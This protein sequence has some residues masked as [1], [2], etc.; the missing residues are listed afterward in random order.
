MTWRAFIVG[1]LL[2]ASIAV[3]DPYTSFNQNYGWNTQSHLPPGA[4]LALV[5]A[6]LALNGVLRLISRKASLK[7]AELMLIW[8]MLIV[9]CAVPSN[10]MRFWPPLMA[11]PAYIAQRPD[12]QWRDTALE[13]APEE[14]LLTKDPHSTAAERF[15]EGWPH[16]EGRVPWSMWLAPMSRWAVL[17]AFFYVATFCMCA[18]MRRQW[19]DRERLQFPLAR[20]PLDFTEGAGKD[21]FLPELFG[22]K[23]FLLGL[24][25]AAGFRALR[26]LPVLFGAEQVWNIS[27]PL[28]DVF[29]GTPL[30]G[31]QL[32]NF[33]LNWIAIGL[34]YLV[35]ADVSLSVWLF[36]LLGRV[37][38]QTSAWLGSTLHHGGTGSQLVRWQR[39]GA[40]ATF[41]VGALYMARRHLRDVI[42]K[43]FGRGENVDD[44]A[45]PIS[46]RVAFWGVVLCSL[47]ALWWF[48]H[49][50]MGLPAALSFF[51][52]LMLTQFAHARIVAQSGLYRTSPLAN[53]PGLLQ[54]L[55]GGG[56]YGPRGAVLANMQ[57]TAMIHGNNSM[58]GPAAIHV[59]RIAKVFKKHRRWLVPAVLAA[60]VVAIVA[61]S[62]TC[63]YQ[64]YYSGGVNFSNQWAVISN[65]QYS[66]QRAHIMIT[67]PTEAEVHWTPLFL[68]VGM[69]SFVMFMRARFYWWPVHSIGILALAE[70]GLDRMWFS[71]LL[72]WL[73]KLGLMKF[74]TGKLMRQGRFFFVGFIVSECAFYSA[75]SLLSFLT[76]GA[77]PGAGGWI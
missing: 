40:Y 21:G 36:Y 16:K 69:T 49:Y 24:F 42:A 29:Q 18:L 61:S 65:P 73:I 70:Y 47:G 15:V 44:G 11:S 31:L 71:F 22:N 28:Q 5:A 57:Y 56:L 60:L 54:A 52:L 12:I 19:V 46:F 66:F 6:T 4:I 55:S 50:G 9:G 23:A 77:V 34:A 8:C 17:M 1:L 63:I 45:E 25:G 53:G 68:G 32:V 67:R 3:I 30:Q 59:L 10:L 2:V 39:L 20:V 7:R 27:I 75:W 35:P 64:A 41:T 43:A 76:G 26:S 37:E 38:L 33:S 14:L 58:L 13:A 48:V 74:T 51:G 72:G 62:W